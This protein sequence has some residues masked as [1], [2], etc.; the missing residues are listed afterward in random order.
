[1]DQNKVISKMYEA[2]QE[3]Q[4]HLEH[5]DNTNSYKIR[6]FGVME[7]LDNLM[8]PVTITKEMVEHVRL[9]TGEGIMA[10]KVALNETYGNIG[11]AIEY[12]RGN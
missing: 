11:E 1:M 5:G 8:K 12:L 9:K 2:L 6:F 3:I 7:E 4:Y 10:C